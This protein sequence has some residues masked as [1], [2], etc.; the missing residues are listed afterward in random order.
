[1]ILDVPISGIVVTLNDSRHLRDCLTA[2]AFC[3]ER[4][5]IDLGSTDDSVKIAQECHAIV[6]PHKHVPRVELLRAE[7]VQLV[8][9]DWILFMDPDEVLA[10]G[11][12]PLLRRTLAQHALAAQIFVPFQYYFLGKPLRGTVWN[13]Q[14]NGRPILFHRHRV[15]LSTSVHRGMLLRDGYQYIRAGGG[16]P[17]LYT[18]HYW[19]DSI[20]QLYLK[21]ARYLEAEGE[22]RYMA[23]ERFSYIRM[24]RCSLSEFKRSLIDHRGYHG[25]NEVF[26][27]VFIAWYVMKSHLSLRRYQKNVGIHKGM[28]KQDPVMRFP[29]E[30]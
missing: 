1:M 9:H 15:E 3:A 19:I 11:I 16:Q 10:D 7:A 23:G 6:V 21:H 14:S 30:R 29:I 25:L 12:E 20:E 24:L 8:Q 2:M 26:L 22:S 13:T 18:K 4:I 27:C 28:T 5:V 17:L